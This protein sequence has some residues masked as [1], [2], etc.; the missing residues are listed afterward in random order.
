MSLH[1]V[2]ELRF[3]SATLDRQLHRHKVHLKGF[4]MSSHTQTNFT[5]KIAEMQKHR[6]DPSFSQM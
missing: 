3:E 4:E 6:C 5:E 2:T 1:G